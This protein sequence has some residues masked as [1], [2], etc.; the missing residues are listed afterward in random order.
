[1]MSMPTALLGISSPIRKIKGVMMMMPIKAT[2][3]STLT[4]ARIALPITLPM[5]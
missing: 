5:K 3:A 1:M 2:W 4:M